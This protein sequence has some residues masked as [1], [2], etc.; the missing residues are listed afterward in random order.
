M[1]TILTLQITI[2]SLVAVGFLLK[3]MKMIGDAGQKNINDMVIYIVLPCNILKA[4]LSSAK[5]GIPADCIGVL[6]ISL[7]IQIFCFFYGKLM[8]RSETEGHRKCLEYATLCSNAG[9]MGN[10]IAEGMFGMEGLMLASIYL[11]PQRIM[12]WSFGLPIFSGSHDTKKTIRTVLTHPCILACAAGILFM[13]GRVQM[14]AAVMG[15]INA[16]GNCN[17]ALSML[18]IGMILEEINIHELFNKTVLLFCLHRLILIPA[19]VYLACLILPVSNT[20]RV[21]SVILAAMPAGATT[22]ILAEKY[23]MEAAFASKLVIISTLLSLPTL[24]LWS[25]LLLGK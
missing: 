5:D 13:A 17:T 10:P 18:M 19:F 4:F 11:I 21:L 2:F 24:F 14:P 22:S 25:M 20:T 7:G 15:P 16:L 6:L 23:N 1:Q 8:Y 12:M 9:F 3:R